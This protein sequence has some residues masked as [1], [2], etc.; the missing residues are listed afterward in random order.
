MRMKMRKKTLP[1][2]KGSVGRGAVAVGVWGSHSHFPLLLC[3]RLFG[4]W[5]HWSLTAEAT[6][7]SLESDMWFQ[8]MSSFIQIYGLYPPKS[9]LSG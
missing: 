3:P 5:D 9:I 6:L 4:L 8:H 7:N 1:V 2:L